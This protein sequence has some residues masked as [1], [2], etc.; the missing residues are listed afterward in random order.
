VVIPNLTGGSPTAE[1]PLET[2]LARCPLESLH[3]RIAVLPRSKEVGRESVGC[4]PESVA[5]SPRTGPS[6]VLV[7]N[8]CICGGLG[9]DQ[10]RP[11]PKVAGLVEWK[12]LDDLVPA[13]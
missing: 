4:K 12:A 1:P 11:V 5:G 6:K 9:T 10:H 7:G 3:W 13:H 8:N 2:A